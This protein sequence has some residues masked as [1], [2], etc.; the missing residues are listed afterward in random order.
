[1]SI[2]EQGLRML[3]CRR[4]GGRSAAAAVARRAG[5]HARSL[6]GAWAFLFANVHAGK[7]AR[8]QACAAID[9]Q[10]GP[11]GKKGRRYALT[12]TSIMLHHPSGQA[13]GQ[14]DDVHNEGRELL[15]LRDYMDTTLSVATGRN[16]DS[17]QSDLERVLYMT[18]K[19]AQEY[20]VID[21]VIKMSPKKQRQFAAAVAARK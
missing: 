12:H 1:M 4:A 19:D 3:H 8:L 20:G 6:R 11:A 14:A 21:H 15:R 5:Q 9:R 18:P 13:G 17:I 2:A 10:R 16:F 7:R